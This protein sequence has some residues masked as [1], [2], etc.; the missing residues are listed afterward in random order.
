MHQLAQFLG[1][2]HDLVRPAAAEHGHALDPRGAQRIEGMRDDVRAGEF[3]ASLG[4]DAGDV[5]SDVSHADHHRV[6]TRQIGGEPGEFG[7]AVVPA[8]ESRAAEDI[9][10]IGPVDRQLAVL[11][12][13][14]R[15]HHRIVETGQLG[16]RHVASDLDVAD[17]AD[18]IAVGRL[19][20]TARDRLD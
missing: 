1:R 9:A 6:P 12:R 5:E 16:D 11:R 3:V 17:E 2:H 18:I 8:D 20:V 7:M 10:R 13:P 19:L 4:Q 14:G 15:Q